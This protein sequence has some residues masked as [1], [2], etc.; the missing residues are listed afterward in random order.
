VDQSISPERQALVDRAREL[1]AQFGDEASAHDVRAAFPAPAMI[2]LR[3]AGFLRL[4]LPPELDGH[5]LWS[6]EPPLAGRFIPY[7]QILAALAAGDASTAQLVQIQTHATGII[8]RHG[9]AEQRQRFLGPVAGRGALIS[10]CG[11]EADPATPG[12]A[13]RKHSE[14]HPAP[15]GFRITATKHFAS[16]AP[17]ADFHLLYLRAPGVAVPGRGTVLV[18]VPAD[19][20]GVSLED[21]WDT[22][23][24]RATVSWS[25]ALDDVFVPWENVLGG[26]GDWVPRDSRTFTLAYAANFLGTAEGACTFVHK[27]VRE[28]PELLKDDVA[29]LQLGEMEAGLQAARASM[30][31]AAGLWEQGHCDE[32]ELA[33]LR[34]MLASKQTALRVTNQAIELVGARGMFRQWPLERALRDVRTFTLHAR[35]SR[36][37]RL[38]AT[39]A[40]GGAFHAKQVYGPRVAP[41]SWEDLGIQPPITV[42]GD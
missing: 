42:A 1:A 5:G 37:A 27:L 25:L 32:A 19:A 14:L 22:L 20:P 7:Y 35:D 26:P 6:L 10:S 36:T 13:R 39:A 31:Y 23:G 4:A 18:V 17:A 24:M 34:A 12:T 11:S 8:A 40:A 2:L 9:N 29:A 41:L 33:G 30:L 28:L 15:G 16:L 21:S 38:I 3:D